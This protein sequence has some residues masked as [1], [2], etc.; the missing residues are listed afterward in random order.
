MFGGTSPNGGRPGPAFSGS[1][2]NKGVEEV[3]TTKLYEL[4]GVAK[5]AT[6]AEIKKAYRK[7]ALKHHPDKGGDP[8]TFK[9]ITH[10]FEVL[11]DPDKRA[12]YD[13]FGEPGLEEDADVEGKHFEAFNG[14][15]K[16][17]KKHKTK[18]VLQPLKVTLDQIYNGDTKKM[19]ITRMVVD[20]A[21]G[22]HVC[23]DCEGKGVTVQVVRMGPRPT[24]QTTSVCNTCGGKGKS[25]AMKRQRDV[26]D[27]PIQKGT[28]PDH[29]VTFKEKADEH[30]DADTG[31][32]IFVV[33]QLEHPVF[34]RKGADLYMHRKI[35]VVEALCGFEIEITHLDNRKLR[36]RSE[37]GDV[38]QGLAQK[39]DPYSRDACKIDWDVLPDADCPDIE[40]AA[41][42]DTDDIEDIMNACETT[43][44]AKGLDVTC[45][46]VF[47]GRAYFRTCPRDEVI[48]GKQEKKG[49]TMYLLPNN[50][51]PNEKRFMK[52][53]RGEGMP[54]LK[55]PFVYGNL[56]LILS[57]EFP[58]AL[59]DATQAKLRKILGNTRLN[60][61]LFSP[62]DQ[63]VEIHQ[64]VDMDPVNSLHSN[65][66]NMEVDHGFDEEAEAGAAAA[67]Q[68][69]ARPG[70]SQQ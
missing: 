23:G 60:E 11:S 40:T 7:L 55:N 61:P 2:K 70:C 17:G 51:V 32:V 28:P 27:V 35:S 25:F 18:D 44:K 10:A 12:K 20:Q 42:A 47:E 22:V 24:F 19:A 63:E 6:D 58:E 16:G 33:K 8:D 45:F 21:K 39:Y 3:D 31:D 34:K 66:V 59:D 13:K 14:G 46:V 64:V 48:S 1:P 65:K 67:A 53:V 26:L 54:T 4:L 49:A 15:K 37:P 69:A 5:D 43:L 41:S 38:V 30:P 68:Q 62:D 9:D 50:D 52:A 36:I 56:F 57:I 29:K